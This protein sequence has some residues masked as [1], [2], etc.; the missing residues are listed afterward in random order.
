MPRW[1]GGQVR[2]IRRFQRQELGDGLT[3][4]CACRCGPLSPVVRC[5][6]A[7]GR[8]YPPYNDRR[9]ALVSSWKAQYQSLQGGTLWQDYS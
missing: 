2:Q 7:R 6:T 3:S 4:G 8:T 5:T 1:L 9:K